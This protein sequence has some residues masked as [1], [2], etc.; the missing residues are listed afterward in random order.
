MS[1]NTCKLTIKQLFQKYKL[2]KK[3]N[4]QQHKREQTKQTKI[5]KKQQH[6]NKQAQ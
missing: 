5:T 3:K 4:I 6:Q 1:S 2:N